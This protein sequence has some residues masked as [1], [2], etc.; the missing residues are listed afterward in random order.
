MLGGMRLFRRF[1]A[2][3]VIVLGMTSVALAQGQQGQNDPNN[4]K[5]DGRSKLHGNQPA[6]APEIDPRSA[7][8][9][10]ALLASGLLMVRGRHRARE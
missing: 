7:T 3:A 2:V 6:A 1:L 5:L 4:G 8:T 9:A 10:L